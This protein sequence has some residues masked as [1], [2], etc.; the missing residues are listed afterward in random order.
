MHSSTSNRFSG[1]NITAKRGDK[2][3]ISNLNFDVSSGHI[4][5]VAGDNGSGKSTLLRLMAGLA[6]P[7][8]GRI[9][10]NDS[11]I[12]KDRFSHYDRLRYVGHLAA[13][14]SE[15]TV[16]ENLRY[17]SKIQNGNANTNL[18]VKALELFK[19]TSER[20]QPTKF[21]SSGQ[22]RKLALTRL[23]IKPTPLWLLDEPTVGLDNEGFSNFQTILDSHCE[24]GG[25]AVIAT[26]DEIH[27]KRPIQ[28]LRLENFKSHK[29]NY[30]ETE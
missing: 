12:T 7:A 8:V 23:I 9:F 16:E 15:L 6:P 22:K 10:W 11:Q 3:L 24:K 4:L 5:S 2:I 26:H 27:L 18:I 13:V 17:W 25:I 19:I 29:L 28:K 20:S 1:E 21:L 14:K 30:Y